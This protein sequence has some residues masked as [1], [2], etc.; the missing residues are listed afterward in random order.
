MEVINAPKPQAMNDRALEYAKGYD[1]TMTAGS[2]C[3]A[4]DAKHLAGI[5]VDRRLA[6]IGDL[7]E[8]LRNREHRLFRI[9]RD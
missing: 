2:D 1:L 6:S 4:T 9:E 8:A 3:H 7:I 5:E